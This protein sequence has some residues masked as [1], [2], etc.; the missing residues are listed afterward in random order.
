MANQKLDQS[1]LLYESKS[2]TKKVGVNRH[3]RAS[4]ASQPMSACLFGLFVTLQYYFTASLLCFVT[5]DCS[6]TLLDF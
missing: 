2:P 1:D 4:W 5:W 6:V 3:F